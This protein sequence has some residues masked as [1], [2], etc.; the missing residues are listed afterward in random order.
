MGIRDDIEQ[1]YQDTYPRYELR[2]E[3]ETD[4]LDM[5]SEEDRQ[6]DKYHYEYQYYSENTKCDQQNGLMGDIEKRGVIKIHKWSSCSLKDFKYFVHM[7]GG[8]RFC[9]YMRNAAK[10][11]SRL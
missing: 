2:N 7:N 10:S 11:N 5:N 8:E 3:Y 9:L 6:Y 1:L 4:S